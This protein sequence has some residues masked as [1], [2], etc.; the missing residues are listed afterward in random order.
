MFLYVPVCGCSMWAGAQRPEDSLEL[1]SLEAVRS[2]VAVLRV[3]PR[4]LAR[5]GGSHNC[6]LI[7][8]SAMLC[9]YECK[10]CK[11]HR[12]KMTDVSLKGFFSLCNT[13]S[14]Y[15]LLC[16][17]DQTVASSHWATHLV[18][19]GRRRCC[20]EQTLLQPNVP[21]HLVCTQRSPGVFLFTV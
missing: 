21:S 7:S 1:E 15:C 14:L 18:H 6:R 12:S 9:F 8:P 4:P 3:E 16:A 11:L 10:V 19:G 2:S 20:V 5:T 17:K 13:A